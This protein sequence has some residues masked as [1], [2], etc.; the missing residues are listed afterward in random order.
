MMMSKNKMLKKNFI[1]C[2]SAFGR[3]GYSNVSNFLIEPTVSV[4]TTTTSPN[5]VTTTGV[6][7]SQDG[8]IPIASL[9]S[10]SDLGPS[11]TATKKSPTPTT[12]LRRAVS[13]YQ[14]D[15][16]PMST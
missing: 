14:Q 11:F 15:Q 8:V 13:F 7:S 3:L 5:V 16:E 1:R 9:F 10:S 6:G 4:T 12:P 2:H